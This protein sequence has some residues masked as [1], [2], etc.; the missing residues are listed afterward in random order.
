[1]ANSSSVT[2]S[3]IAAKW[4]NDVGGDIEVVML[5]ESG[6]KGNTHIPFADTS[7]EEVLGMMEG[8]WVRRSWMG[9]KTET[10]MRTIESGGQ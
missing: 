5:G 6:L 4:I 10:T 2:D 1:M 3:R 9:M 7:N 8:G